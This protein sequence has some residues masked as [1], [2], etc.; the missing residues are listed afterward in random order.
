MEGTKQ[1]MQVIHEMRSEIIK[2]ERE[3]RALR[4]E[5]QFDGSKGAKQ[6]EG[7]GEDAGKE[8]AWNLTD[9]AG[10]AAVALRRNVS[11]GSALMLQEQKGNIMTV[12]RYSISSSVHSLPGNKHHKTDKRNPFKGAL[13]VK[14]I[15][16]QSA[17]PT[18]IQLT[19]KEEKGF[20]KIPSDCLSSSSSN[21][22]RSFQDHVYK[23]RGKVKAVSFLL[24]VD[25]S[26]YS[27]NQ[28]SFTCQQNQNTKQLSPIIEKDM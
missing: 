2:L 1:L 3:N 11:A 26:P 12:R 5:L 7:T 18:D 6:E 24:P 25:M 10:E 14:G 15:I 4:G 22:R 21:K 13:E 19:N 16:K 9:S 8:E 23:C 28:G 27:E 20:A 17:F